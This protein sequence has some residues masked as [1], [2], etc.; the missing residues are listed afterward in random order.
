MEGTIDV[1]LL[2]FVIY[3]VSVTWGG[4]VNMMFLYITTAPQH[5]S[6]LKQFITAAIV[7]KEQLCSRFS[8]VDE[9]VVSRCADSVCLPR[10]KL[11]DAEVVTVGDS[12]ER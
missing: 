8:R 12:C 6:P 9:A 11:S 4:R 7:I 1:Y 10:S 2:A 3:A 5:R